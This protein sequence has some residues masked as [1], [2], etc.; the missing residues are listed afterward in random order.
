MGAV[1]GLRNI[2][3]AAQAAALVK[4]HTKHSLLVGEQAGAFAAEMGLPWSSLTTQVRF[5][6]FLVC[7]KLQAYL[8]V[9]LLLFLFYTR[10]G[11]KTSREHSHA[12]H[13]KHPH[14]LEW[15]NSTITI[16]FPS[17]CSY[18]NRIIY[19]ILCTLEQ[20]ANHWC[21]RCGA[22]LLVTT[23]DTDN[24]NF[25]VYL[26]ASKENNV[27]FT[28]RRC[29]AGLRG[30]E[31]GVATGQLPAQLST[32]GSAQRGV[33]LWPLR[34]CFWCAHAHHILGGQ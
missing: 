24:L 16:V 3:S 19:C 8:H 2:K 29:G 15:H 31:Q 22:G 7:L 13:T 5:C 4:D 28:G 34:H 14:S 20:Y 33:F 12:K 11:S 30:A 17:N 9:Q 32:R 21:R 25:W 23:T 27:P 6:I 26:S 1:G 18:S 10:I